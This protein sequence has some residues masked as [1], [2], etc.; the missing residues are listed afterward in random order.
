MEMVMK[1]QGRK[2]SLTLIVVQTIQCQQQ[3]DGY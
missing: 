2:K 1:E 3:H